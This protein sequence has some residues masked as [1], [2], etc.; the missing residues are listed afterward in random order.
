MVQRVGSFLRKSRQ[1]MRL[2][3]REKGKISLSQYFQQFKVGDKVA[4]KIHPGVFEG[5]FF[6]RFQGL[7]GNVVGKRGTC[8]EI[9]I[10]DG[11]KTKKIVVHPIHLKKITS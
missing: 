11:G 4:L 9:M 3:F 10:K 6:P 2:D 1:K 7:C 8:Y 5:R